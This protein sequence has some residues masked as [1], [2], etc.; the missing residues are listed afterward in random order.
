VAAKDSKP[1]LADGLQSIVEKR[2]GHASPASARPAKDR[3]DAEK[4]LRDARL[5]KAG[6]KTLVVPSSASRPT[7][8]MLPQLSPALTPRAPS[9]SARDVVVLPAITGAS[10]CHDLVHSINP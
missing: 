1:R 6:S 3:E 7:T 5:H 9:A 8:G 4:R 10:V 2:A